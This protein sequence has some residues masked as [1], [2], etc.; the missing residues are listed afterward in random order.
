MGRCCDIIFLN[1]SSAVRRVVFL[2]SK[3]EGLM[4][5]CQGQKMGLS[6]E[7]RECVGRAS[8]A[9]PTRSLVVRRVLEGR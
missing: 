2:L 4:G 3:I 5:D 1:L 9:L 8:D 7:N 6:K